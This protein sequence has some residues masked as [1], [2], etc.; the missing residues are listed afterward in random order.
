MAMLAERGW[1]SR[2]V[3]ASG[4][5]VALSLGILRAFLT[6]DGRISGVRDWLAVSAIIAPPAVAAALIWSRRVGAQILARACWWSILV[7]GTLTLAT[8]SPAGTE[9]GR[10]QLFAGVLCAG[11]ALLAVGRSGLDATRGR[12]QPVAFRGTL[13]LSLLLAMADCG[14]F[15]FMS[16][17]ALAASHPIRHELFIGLGLFALTLTGVVGLLRLRTWGLLVALVTNVLVGALAWSGFFGSHGPLRVLFMTTAALQLVVPLPMIVT[18]VRRR[19]PPPDR[20]QNV[21]VVGATVVIVA[22]AAV[23]AYAGLAHR[24]SALLSVREIL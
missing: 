17:F 10:R 11:A 12:F 6:A 22:L 24:T 23:S 15:G 21:R 3:F 2:R 7:F 5:S 4:L 16:L 20:W 1:A 8:I 19:P 13:L 18:L 9:S 14:P